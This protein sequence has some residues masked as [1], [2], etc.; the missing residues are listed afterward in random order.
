MIWDYIN[1]FLVQYVFGGYVNGQNY[2]G[3]IGT[4]F[5]DDG[6]YMA[7]DGYT[8]ASVL[9]NSGLK[10]SADC[11]PLYMTLGNYLATTATIII[12]CLIVF[13]FVMLVRWVYKTVVSAFLLR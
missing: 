3:V 12:M 9:V 10:D 11:A 5:Y 7:S 13:L 1:E 2:G 6:G 4:L 8:T